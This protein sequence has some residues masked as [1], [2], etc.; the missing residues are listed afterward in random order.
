MARCLACG[1][2]INDGAEICSSDCLVAWLRVSGASE[3]DIDKA[4]KSTPGNGVWV[5][6]ATVETETLQ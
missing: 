6:V 4:L 3:S 5:R 2:G 1:K